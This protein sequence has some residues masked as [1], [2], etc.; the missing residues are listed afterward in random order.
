VGINEQNSI[1]EC[2]SKTARRLRLIQVDFA[3]ENEQSRVE[4]LREEIDRSLK[5]LM[6]EQ[7]KVF[8]KRLL[9]IFPVCQ[10]GAVATPSTAHVDGDQVRDPDFVVCCLEEMLPSLTEDQK[11]LLTRRLDDLG[12]APK[13]KQGGACEF[14]QVLKDQLH[15]G[16]ESDIK[17]EQVASLEKLSTLFM[18][19]LGPLAWK[20]WRKLSPR[21]SI[22]SSGN[23]KSLVGRFVRGDTNASEQAVEEELLKL[24]RLIAGM[25]AAVDQVSKRFAEGHLDNFSPKEIVDKVQKERGSAFVSHEVKCWRKYSELADVYM[26]ENSITLKLREYIADYVESAVSLNQ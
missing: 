18:L 11:R 3:D 12:L 1:E 6:P 26:T 20:A 7:K 22:R 21:S 25:M 16:G 24:Q 2:V 23:F 8:L 4:Y 15:L 17:S 14:G 5:T 19:K 13:A 9:A 10:Q